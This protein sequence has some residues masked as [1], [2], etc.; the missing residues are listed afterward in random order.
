ML[1][2]SPAWSTWAQSE[3]DAAYNNTAACPHAA[4]TLAGLTKRSADLRAAHMNG[5]DVAY[6]LEPRQRLDVF[7]APGRAR[8]LYVFIHGGYWLR[9]HKDM[10]AAL[11]VAPLTCGFNV[12]MIGYTLAPAASLFQIVA[13]VGAAIAF[14]MQHAERLQISVDRVV[15]GGWSA[16]G[17]L[18][19]LMAERLDIDAAIAVS[20]IFDLEP[21][22]HCSMNATL[23]LTGHEADALSPLHRI[24]PTTKPMALIYG[25]AELS[26]LQRQ[27]CDYAEARRHHGAPCQLTGLAGVDH[28]SILDRVAAFDGPVVDFLITL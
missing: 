1:G 24:A 8:G 2:A 3:L 17:H 5:L 27:S 26:E 12:A 22:R 23:G 13:E 7:H 11:A 14:L 21:L 9:N 25:L 16:G 18:A 20:G 15:V 6:G 4:A 10:F 28:F 19:A